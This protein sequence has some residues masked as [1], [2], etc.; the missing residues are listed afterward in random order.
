MLMVAMV[1]G[2]FFF[3]GA[4]WILVPQPGIEPTPLAVKEWSP[5]H[6]TAREFLVAMFSDHGQCAGAHCSELY[7]HYL[8]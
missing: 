4:G 7:L 8:I 5:N 6:W 3:G 2:F 1:F